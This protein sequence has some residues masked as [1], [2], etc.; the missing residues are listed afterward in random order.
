MEPKTSTSDLKDIGE[1]KK[2][3]HL[4]K[5]LLGIMLTE[6]SEKPPKCNRATTP[7]PCQTHT[8]IKPNVS[9][10]TQNLS[11]KIYESPFPL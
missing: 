1:N 4:L 3:Q 6:S 7:N 9:I 5:R 2:Q 10:E 11:G 8:K